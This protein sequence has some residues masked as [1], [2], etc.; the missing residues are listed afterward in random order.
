MYTPVDALENLKSRLVNWIRLQVKDACAGGCVVG[1]SGGIDSAV[2]AAL[3][4]EAMPGNVLG[5]HMPCYGNPQDTEDARLVADSLKIGYKEIHLEEAFDCI[6]AALLL[7]RKSHEMDALGSNHAL[8]ENAEKLA[9]S[10]IKPRLRMIVLYYHANL[11][12][13][14]VA[15]TGNRSELEVGYFTKYGDGGVD[16]L[17]LGGLVKTQVRELTRHLGIHARVIYKAPTAGLWEGQT[18]EGEL[19]FTYAQLDEI[20]LTGKGDERVA[21]EVMKRKQAC[22]HKLR[23]PLI[24]D[25]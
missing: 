25:F 11:Y 2:V 24:P 18:D 1:I 20:I 17:P 8:L 4:K 5:I 21:G 16:I 15:G 3:C 13:Y 22:G 9:I 23:A 14:L 12:D 19:G 7:S 6:T 10:N